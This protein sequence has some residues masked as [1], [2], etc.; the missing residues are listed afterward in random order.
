MKQSFWLYTLAALL[1]LSGCAAPKIGFLSPDQA[2]LKESTLQ[3]RGKDKVVM[4]T[5]RGLLSNQP[6]SGLIKKRP[7]LV[8]EVVSQLR[9]AESDPQIGAVV[10]KV[11]SPGGSVTASDQ[12]YYEIASFKQRTGI[13]VVVA[14]MDVAASGGYYL[15]LPADHIQAHPTTVTGSV[16]VIFIQPRFYGMMEK[17][18]VQVDI[19]RSG[20]N[21]DMGSPFRE[22]TKEENRIIQEVTDK[23]AER[24]IKRVVGHRNL[25]ARQMQE[26]ASGRIYLADDAK[27]AG[28][29]DSIG[30]L[31][32]AI[33]KAIQLAGFAKDAKVVVYRRAQYP[34][35]NPYNT[36]TNLA[37][38][39]KL[40]MINIDLA[41]TLSAMNTGYY[42]VWSPAAAGE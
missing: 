18:G 35:D 40:S 1:L 8:Q 31:D 28:L 39:G 5:V 42:Y 17:I 24:F 12:L 30:Y 11:N 23:L 33:A 27:A 16:G 7:G 13:K 37:E 32:D 4:I 34:N 15:S 20:R 29:V 19:N 9:K 21:K 10:L 2:P 25:S 41:D 26:I 3:G 38:T 22:S 36:A 6:K 14:M